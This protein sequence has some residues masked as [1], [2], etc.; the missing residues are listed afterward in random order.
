MTS[1]STTKI[2]KL[3]TR[4]QVKP[5]DTWDLS[6]LFERCRLG[7]GLHRR[8]KS[9]F[10]GTKSSAARSA[11]GP[12]A[13]AKCFAFDSDFDR[14][15]ERLGTYA[16][17]KTAEDMADSTYQRMLGRYEHAATRAAEAA[18]FIR[19]EILALPD[20]EAER[21]RRREAAASRSSCSSSG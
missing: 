8:G 21:V 14:A 9:R 17:L 5:A 12:A 11:N 16:Y 3:P 18:S 19:P 10:R 4:R 20:E 15:S 6:S 7:A 13:L 1:A 2:K